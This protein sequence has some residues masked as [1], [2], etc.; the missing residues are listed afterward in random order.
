MGNDS[1]LTN[2]NPKA[3]I[4]RVLIKLREDLLITL[5][6]FSNFKKNTPSQFE[7]INKQAVMNDFTK[8]L[9]QRQIHQLYKSR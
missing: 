1:F 4:H 8:L 6:P 3:Y 9:Y 5:A 7:R 2:H